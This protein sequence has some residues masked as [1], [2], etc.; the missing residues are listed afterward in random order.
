M[1]KSLKAFALTFLLIQGCT[2]AQQATEVNSVR[3]S[4]APYLKMDCTALSTELN[5]LYREA[6]ISSQQ[7][8]SKYNSDKNAEVV[9][10][11]LFWPAAFAIDGNQEEA[12]KLASIKGQIEAIQE[13]LVINGCQVR[14][15]PPSPKNQTFNKDEDKA[16]PMRPSGKSKNPGIYTP[17]KN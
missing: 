6:S 4:V 15:E 3:F 2:T 13:A 8:D 9:A 1:T 12:A 14:Y 10:W 11:I 5:F 16:S 7:V 17:F